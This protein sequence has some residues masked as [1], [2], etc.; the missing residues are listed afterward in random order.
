MN[1]DSR[2][3]KVAYFSME[4]ALEPSMPTYAGGLVNLG[5]VQSKLGLLK[6]GV[7]SLHF[8][9]SLWKMLRDADLR[10]R[11]NYHDR[12]AVARNIFGDTAR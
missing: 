6:E 12:C 2:P 3:P 9:P 1:S 10:T 4:I 7:E 8:D 11:S 5:S